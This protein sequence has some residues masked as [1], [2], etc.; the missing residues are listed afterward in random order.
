M[1]DGNTA[2]MAGFLGM[3][4]DG[5]ISKLGRGLSDTTAK[6]LAVALKADRCDIYTD[7][8]GIHTIDLWIVSVA[9]RLN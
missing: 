7:V 8:D 6:A 5:R 1:R 2:V 9:W 4:E 3:I